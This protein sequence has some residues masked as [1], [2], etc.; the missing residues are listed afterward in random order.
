LLGKLITDNEALAKYYV[1]EFEKRS[2]Y[3]TD[4]LH[5]D[6][7][8]AARIGMIR[9]LDVWKPDEGGFSSVAFWWA[10]HEMQLVT[11]HASGISVPKSA[12]MP[13]KKQTEIARFV[14][15]HGRDPL[16]EEVGL[17]E[18]AFE[19]ARKANVCMVPDGEAD[20][21]ALEET[22][23]AESCFDRKRDM[24]ALKEFV[25]GLS[26]KK[27]KEFWTGAN[28]ELTQQAKTYVEEK[29]ACRAKK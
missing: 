18:K 9:A 23:D 25:H 21:V 29:R 11:R 26:A 15:M 2:N 6:L 3:Y 19:R 17:T 1:R 27:Q 5:E 7:L 14:T 8:Q 13:P 22:E 16:P 4:N 12:F 10:I 20:D 28:P 24:A